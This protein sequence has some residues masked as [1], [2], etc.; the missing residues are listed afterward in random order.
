MI[1]GI[2]KANNKKEYLQLFY[3]HIF[4]SYQTLTEEKLLVSNSNYRY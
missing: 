1:I 4:I 3:N 2:I